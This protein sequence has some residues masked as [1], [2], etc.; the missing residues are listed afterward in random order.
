[1]LAVAALIGAAM[2]AAVYSNPRIARAPLAPPVIAD[3]PAETP[4]RPDAA[5][6]GPTPT[7]LP[8]SPSQLPGWIFGLLSGVCAAAIAIILL[9]L[10]WV[11]LR[12]RLTLRRGLAAP[13]PGEVPTLAQTQARVRGAIE[14]GLAELDVADQDPRRAIIACWLRLEEAATA[15]GTPRQI[16]DTST[17][18]VRRL[19]SNHAVSADVLDGLAAVYREARFAAHAINPDLRDQA[20]RA[21]HHLRH[22]LT[23]GVQ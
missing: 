13:D 16:G 6:A 23:V 9:S 18:L 10:L 17:D 4:A 7:G 5:T 14:E 11:M 2:L 19:L 21:L 15:A 1:V 3:A 12:D 22:E 20:R 8:S